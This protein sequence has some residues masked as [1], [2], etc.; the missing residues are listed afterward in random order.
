[1]WCRSA[2][3]SLLLAGW[4]VLPAAAAWGHAS[5]ELPRARLS[6]EGRHVFVEWTAPPDD[7]ADVGVA[8]GLFP[9]QA[10][11]AL[12][13]ASD[14]G[15]PSDDQIRALSRSAE[16]RG[17]LLDNVRVTQHDRPCA[18]EVDPGDDFLADGAR[19][20]FTCAEPVEAAMVEVTLLHDRDESY[21]TYSVDGT[22][23]YAVHTAR[24][25]EHPWDFTLAAEQDPTVEPALLAGGAA[26]AFVIGGTLWFLGRRTDRARGEA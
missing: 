11:V 26:V 9:E 10:V 7:A 25:P 21:A 13:G 6:S 3:L 24:Q 16:L 5:G 8:V 14:E 15:L 4:L 18:A 19:F 1:M 23:Q 22:S 12:L 2:C 20:V 17:Y